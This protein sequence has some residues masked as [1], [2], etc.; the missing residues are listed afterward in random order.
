MTDKLIATKKILKNFNNRIQARKK[1]AK[2][3]DQSFPELNDSNIDRWTR[4]ECYI[5]INA[6]PGYDLIK[7]SQEKLLIPEIFSQP[8]LQFYREWLDKNL[9]IQD[10]KQYIIDPP[11]KNHTLLQYLHHLHK[12]ISIKRKLTAR[13]K[14][15]LRSFAN[16]IRKEYL[17]EETGFLDI[18]FPKKMDFFRGKVI[19]KIPLEVY[20]IDILDTCSILKQLAYYI[21][22]GRPNFQQSAA[23]A[24]ALAW[25]CL[26]SA[27]ARTLT[28]E[29]LLH[30]ITSN[31]LKIKKTPTKHNPNSDT[32][33]L[34]L[35]TLFWEEKIIISKT[36]YD[37]LL[38]LC[39]TNQGLLFKRSLKKLRDSFNNIIVKSKLSANPAEISFLTFLSEP[40]DAIGHRYKPKNN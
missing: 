20:P 1:I 21:L 32:H 18:I 36:L 3:M 38:A 2:S 33:Y 26:T 19:R 17:P 27:K 6:E 13:W 31:H 15:S 37:Y 34:H 12:L 11:L 24:L 23:E 28:E 29:K 40:H 14:T 25:I 8:A 10:Y 30:T 39:Q 16:F 7:P 4:D 9:D 22:N 5:W 35:P